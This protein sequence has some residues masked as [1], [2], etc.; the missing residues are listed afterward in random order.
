M[1]TRRFIGAVALALGLAACSEAVVETLA[2]TSTSLLSAAGSTSS[3]TATTTTNPTTTTTSVAVVSAELQSVID[4]AL[5]EWSSGD[6]E[7]WRATFAVEAYVRAGFTRYPIDDHDKDQFEFWAVLDSRWQ[8]RE[9]VP[10]DSLVGE[11]ATCELETSHLFTDQWGISPLVATYS[12]DVA[13]GLIVYYEFG[14]IKN[15][16]VIHG[17][18][19]D[20]DAWVLEKHPEDVAA[21]IGIPDDA[22]KAEIVIGHMAEYFAD[23]PSI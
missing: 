12:F 3:T 8:S 20:F 15:N 21:I 4:N 22:A 23:G 11:A 6:T 9:Y 2:T 7:R 17:A 5:V 16:A 1:V 14:G 19:D 13:E 10:A 18:W